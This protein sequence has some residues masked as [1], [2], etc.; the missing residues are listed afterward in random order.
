MQLIK[1]EFK[2]KHKIY[3]GKMKKKKEM[4]MQFLI[5]EE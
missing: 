5:K 3:F 1:K 4:A 2:K